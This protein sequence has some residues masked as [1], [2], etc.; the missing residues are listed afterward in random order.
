MYGRI[1][2]FTYFE[3]KDWFDIQTLDLDAEFTI[4]DGL[5]PDAVETDFL[6]APDEHK[7]TFITKSSISINP[8]PVRRFWE[9]ALIAVKDEGDYVHVDVVTSKE[10]STKIHTAREVRRLEIDL[11]YS[12]AGIGSLS[13]E[14]I[15]EDL[16][17]SN[18]K[19]AKIVAT[20]KPNESLQIQE[21]TI[22]TGG[23]ELAEEDGEASARI[24]DE[25]GN[26]VNI[27]TKQFP[28]KN[29]FDSNSIHLFENLY[30]K[31]KG[32]WPRQN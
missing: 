8:Y 6:F 17:K 3:N 26:L 28:K 7:F 13:K 1:A 5:F 25:S 29:F 31:I 14:I 30:D 20:A 10:F 27:S 15:D 23:I 11:N 16:R 2:Q 32:L 4:R 21:S 24:V 22:L 12:N 18:A 19:A 9:E